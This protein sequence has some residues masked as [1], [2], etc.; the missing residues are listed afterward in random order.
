MEQKTVVGRDGS[1]T[2]ESKHRREEEE[3]SGGQGWCSLAVLALSA[4][5]VVL[6]LLLLAL[7]LLPTKH[8]LELRR[9]LLRNTPDLPQGTE[10]ALTG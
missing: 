4:L 9:C 7:L 5:L 1:S 2:M 6:L 3:R 10:P 8:S